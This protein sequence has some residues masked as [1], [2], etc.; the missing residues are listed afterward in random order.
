VDQRSTTN[1][2]PQQGKNQ[3]CRSHNPVDVGS[4]GY[5]GNQK[6]EERERER[7]RERRNGS[8]GAQLFCTGENGEIE[9]RGGTRKEL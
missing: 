6:K 4:M 7:E 9:R 3:I 2:N 8:T 1:L 5:R